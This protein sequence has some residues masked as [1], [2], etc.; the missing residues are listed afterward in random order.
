M[1]IPIILGAVG[2]GSAIAGIAGVISGKKKSN[3]AKKLL[4]EA[5]QTR[6]RI[7]ESLNPKIANT[8]ENFDRLGRVELEIFNSFKFISEISEKI[9]NFND[10]IPLSPL[11]DNRR[12]GTKKDFKEHSVNRY[13]IPKYDPEE[14]RM[15]SNFA[16]TLLDGMSGI[17][18]GTIG[19]LAARGMTVAAVSAFGT[20]GTG[21]AI[22]GLHGIAATNAILAFL[23]GGTLAAGGAG[24]LWGNFVLGG[25]TVGIGL[26]IKGGRDHF[27]G[28]K[29][30]AEI[31]EYFDCIK[32]I[33]KALP[34]I[35]QRLAEIDSTVLGFMFNLNMVNSIFKKHVEALK[36]VI[37]DEDRTDWNMYTECEKMLIQNTFLLVR[38]F[39]DVCKVR[40]ILEPESGQLI[41]ELNRE[42]IDNALQK[43]I[44]ISAQCII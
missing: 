33:E 28:K 43:M 18:A 19:G 7:A 16:A 14:V 36:H 40:F 25:V 44:D 12:Q 9:N 37:I 13:S 23:G 3:E 15:I 38:L 17:A 27:K 31:K 21:A 24:M 20:A 4:E 10:I 22:G 11:L 39:I 30:L 42:E 32:N 1:P 35:Y 26:L 5:N 34:Q 29:N 41:G 6:D 8:N 2:V